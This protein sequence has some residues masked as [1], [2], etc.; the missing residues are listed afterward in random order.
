MEYGDEWGNRGFQVGCQSGRY[1]CKCD[2]IILCVFLF[3][4][5]VMATG[6]VVCD[7]VG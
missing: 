4:V 5:I 2:Q 6:Y 1:C 7:S 3:L